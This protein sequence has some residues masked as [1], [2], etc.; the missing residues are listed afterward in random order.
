MR[1]SRPKATA[2]RNKPSDLILRRAKARET[3]RFPSPLPT[4]TPKFIAVVHILVQYKIVVNFVQYVDLCVAA[5][6]IQSQ[7]CFSAM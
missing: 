3:E 6:C 5:C 2:P 4:H 1:F 7:P